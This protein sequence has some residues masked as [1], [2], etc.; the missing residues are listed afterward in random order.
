M[1][2]SFLT[3]LICRV[4]AENKRTVLLVLRAVLHPTRRPLGD[5]DLQPPRLSLAAENSPGRR[6]P[7]IRFR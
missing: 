7:T 2:T 4:A 1:N 6:R 5:K 3:A